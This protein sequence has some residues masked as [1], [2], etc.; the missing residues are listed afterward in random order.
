MGYHSVWASEHITVP[1]VDEERFGKGYYD[2][3][4]VLAYVVAVNER[5]LLGTS[6]IILLLRDPLHLAQVAA[7]VDQLSAGRLILRVGVGSTEGEF[8]TLGANW[9]ERGVVVNEAIQVLEHAWTADRPD[10][11]GRF[12]TFSDI[13]CYPLMVQR[14]HPP[15]W[16]RGGSAQSIPRRRSKG[17]A[18]RPS[19]PSFEHLATGI[20]RVRELAARAGRDPASIEVVVRHPMKITDRASGRMQVTTSSVGDPE[21]W[22][23]IDHSGRSWSRWAS[24]RRW[25]WST[26]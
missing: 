9:E 4:T 2:P 26:W 10:F 12:N 3:F 16:V 1:Y 8:R 11:L 21:I 6:I 17:L 25:V 7:T 24:S 14:P 5:V 23:L 20:P 15:I 19:R 13:N 18:W 22:L